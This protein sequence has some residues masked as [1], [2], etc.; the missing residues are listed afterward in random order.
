M[1]K[2]EIV[3][4]FQAQDTDGSPYASFVVRTV[5]EYDRSRIKSARVDPMQYHVEISEPP[6]GVPEWVE[7]GTARFTDVAT[8]HARWVARLTNA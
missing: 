6:S 5:W 2:G 8:A 1:H 3:T 4:T 7:N